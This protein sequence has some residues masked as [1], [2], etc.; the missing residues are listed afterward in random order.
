MSRKYTRKEII[1]K[2]TEIHGDKYGYDKIKYVNRYTHVK[3]KRKKHK[4]YFKQKPSRHI[5][6]RGC[7]KCGIEKSANS[8]R[9]P[10]EQWEREV[11]KKHKNFYDYSLVK[12]VNDSGKVKIICPE[13]GIFEQSA[14]EHKGHGCQKCGYITMANIYRKPQEQW[15]QESN[16]KHKN[17]YDYSLVKYV[18]DSGKVKIICPEHGI[19]EQAAGNHIRGQGCPTCKGHKGE[20]KIMRHL[21]ENNILIE[22]QKSFPDCKDK[23]LLKFDFYLP[24]YNILIEYDGEQHF[25]PVNFFGGEKSYKI[26]K[27]RDRIKNKYC[28]KNNIRLIRIPYTEFDNIEKILNKI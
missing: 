27:K 6:G 7:P 1:E 13:H 22:T 12:Y 10:Q 11:N 28:K 25:K 24:E 2:F 17:F 18:N 3:I 15:E 19:F 14:G 8:Q 23:G 26:R 9:K 5:M 20:I 16:D 21:L 4:E